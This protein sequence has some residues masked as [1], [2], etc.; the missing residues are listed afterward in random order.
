M[1]R[2]CMCV[3]ERAQ[4]KMDTHSCLTFLHKHTHLWSNLSKTEKTT[5]N[6]KVQII[7]S[8]QRKKIGGGTVVKLMKVLFNIVCMM[9]VYSSKHSCVYVQY[10]CYC[11]MYVHYRLCLHLYYKRSSV[12]SLYNKNWLK[13]VCRLTFGARSL[14]LNAGIG[15]YIFSL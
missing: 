4:W 12:P 6:V 15:I 1:W 8:K 7:C 14:F 9:Y 10:V 3:W 2:R 11:V 5:I 13:K